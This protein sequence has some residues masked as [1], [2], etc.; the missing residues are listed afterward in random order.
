MPVMLHGQSGSRMSGLEIQTPEYAHPPLVESWLAVDFVDGRERFSV[1]SAALRAQLGPEWSSSWK[2]VDEESLSEDRQLLNL[3][4]DRAV[5]LTT[6]GFAF[7]WLGHQGEHY[8]RYETIRDGFVSALDAVCG[9]ARERNHELI[10]QRWAVRYT[11][12]IPRGTVWQTPEDWRFF[13]F[14][15]PMPLAGLGIEAT[16]YKGRWELPL[17]N[18]LGTLTVKFRHAAGQS[19]DDLDAVW[20]T[21]QAK[22]RI[23]DDNDS[24]LF[25]G[26]D[27]GREL[28][29]RAFN[30][31]VSSDAKAFWGVAPNSR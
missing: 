11:N 2:L 4:G 16:G 5:R 24:G 31:L 27:H 15:Q 17:A 9:V 14:W 18:D 28:I 20:L 19:P 26:L 12:R 1:D 25:D 23:N 6:R 22:G 21:L 3:M 7:G 10:P 13:R 30:E 29:V 8:P